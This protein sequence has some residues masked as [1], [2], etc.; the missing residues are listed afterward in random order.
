LPN[1]KN[2]LETVRQFPTMEQ[3]KKKIN[4]LLYSILEAERCDK[5][6]MRAHILENYA[7]LPQEHRLTIWKLMLGISNIFHSQDYLSNQIHTK[8]YE[9]LTHVLTQ[10]LKVN[11]NRSDQ[12]NY[13]LYLLDKEHLP[14]NMEDILSDCQPFCLVYNQMRE[15]LDDKTNVE[16]YFITV[17]FYTNLRLNLKSMKTK[18]NSL[19]QEQF[20]DSPSKQ[21]NIDRINVDQYLL[22]GLAGVFKD[23]KMYHIIWDRC[24]MGEYDMLVYALVSICGEEHCLKY[25]KNAEY[26]FTENRAPADVAKLDET[27]LLKGITKCY[28]Q[29]FPHNQAMQK[30]IVNYFNTK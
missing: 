23:I 6:K 10:V 2:R 26:S 18:F 19:I 5:A 14:L 9:Y 17:E 28:K 24:I 12:F 11:M 20:K 30:L 25:L 15:M 29:Q 13:C 3:N 1:K 4:A 16:C 27:K 8:H 22:T 21:T 7:S